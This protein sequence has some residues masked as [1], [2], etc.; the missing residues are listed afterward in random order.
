MDLVGVAKSNV[1][2]GDFNGKKKERKKKE[3]KKKKRKR[4]FPMRIA[5]IVWNI[6]SVFSEEEMRLWCIPHLFISL[7]CAL[8]EFFFPFFFIC[9]L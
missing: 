8:S 7:A 2:L 6:W 1:K 3:K 9:S 5:S 4:R